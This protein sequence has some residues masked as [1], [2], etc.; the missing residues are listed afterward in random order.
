MDNIV[1]QSDSA[2]QKFTLPLELYLARDTHR[3]LVSNFDQK[4][5]SA[6]SGVDYTHSIA[7]KQTGPNAHVR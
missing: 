7:G 2:G 6:P 3:T 5:I 4:N 1:P